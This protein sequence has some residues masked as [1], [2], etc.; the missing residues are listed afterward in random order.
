MTKRS[1]KPPAGLS[2]EARGLWRR[3]LAEYEFEDSASLELLHELCR[4]IDRLREVQ[5]E[6]EATGLT[7]PGASGQPRA[8]PLLQVEDALRRTVLAHVRALRLT[9]LEV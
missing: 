5:R 2:T 3:L 1:S 8:N 7:V 9:S 4:S 6:I